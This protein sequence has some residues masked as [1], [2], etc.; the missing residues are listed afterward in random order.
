MSKP[1]EEGVSGPNNPIDQL[2]ALMPGLTGKDLRLALN[3]LQKFAHRCVMEFGVLEEDEGDIPLLKLY[4]I[5]HYITAVNQLIEQG[6]LASRLAGTGPEVLDDLGELTID[7]YVHTRY[8][9]FVPYFAILSHILRAGN[10]PVAGHEL[11]LSTLVF[12]KEQCRRANRRA[13]S[14]DGYLA[15]ATIHV[16]TKGDRSRTIVSDSVLPF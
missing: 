5:Q 13:L 6:D 3:E 12:E 2:T 9:S 7:Q 8:R 4:E 16:A 14:T 10:A 15:N 11:I 1:L